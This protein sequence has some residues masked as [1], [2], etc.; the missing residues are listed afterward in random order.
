MCFRAYY[1]ELVII[2]LQS[3]VGYIISSY[4]DCV[5]TDLLTLADFFGSAYQV[6][7]MPSFLNESNSYHQLK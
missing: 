2:L 4:Q 3:N 1:A 5:C 6:F 7:R